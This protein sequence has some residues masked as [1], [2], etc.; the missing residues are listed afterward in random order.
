MMATRILLFWSVVFVALPAFADSGRDDDLRGLPPDV[1]AELLCEREGDKSV[2]ENL[3]RMKERVPDH[4]IAWLRAG[5]SGTLGAGSDSSGVGLGAHVDGSLGL[6]HP[7]YL[8]ANVRWMSATQVQLD[9]LVGFNFRSYGNKWIKAGAS[10]TGRVAYSWSS[11]CQVRRTDYAVVAGGK[12][13]LQEAARGPQLTITES[14]AAGR[15]PGA[16]HITALQ[17]GVQQVERRTAN[18]PGGGWSFSLLYDPLNEG[19][20]AQG[21][22]Q[23][24]GIILFFPGPKMAYTGVSAGA[25]FSRNYDSLPFW[26]TLDLGVA[27]EL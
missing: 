21:G 22:F 23:G 10:V 16:R 6:L 19:Y 27:F 9:A 25:M 26:L 1:R 12:Y 20:G 7:L 4:Y 14:D 3:E 2:L 24:Q 5:L 8:G 15:I 18:S 17:L 11:N 13:L